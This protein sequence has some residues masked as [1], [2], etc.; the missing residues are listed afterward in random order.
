MFARNLRASKAGGHYSAWYHG[1][2]NKASI[3]CFLHRNYHVI[4]AQD[5]PS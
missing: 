2:G 5:S 4:F 1:E 3:N